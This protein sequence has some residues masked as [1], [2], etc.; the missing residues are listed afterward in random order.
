M[1]KSIISLHQRSTYFVRLN[2][3]NIVFLQCIAIKTKEWASKQYKSLQEALFQ[4]H[5]FEEVVYGYSFIPY[6]FGK[7]I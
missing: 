6:L 1:D 2:L 5:L 4:V 3:I 7:L